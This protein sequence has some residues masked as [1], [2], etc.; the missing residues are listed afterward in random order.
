MSRVMP[1]TRA[2]GEAVRSTSSG[3]LPPVLP[4]VVLLSA[5]P[6]MG[7]HAADKPDRLDV[8]LAIEAAMDRST[9][10]VGCLGI[11]QMGGGV[12]W[13]KWRGSGEA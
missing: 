3:P 9:R 11:E 12:G 6:Q 8:A 4:P 5:C 7:G 1:P 13:R 2:K 10:N